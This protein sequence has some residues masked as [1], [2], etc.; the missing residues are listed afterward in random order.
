MMDELIK[1]FLMIIAGCGAIFVCVLTF[2]LL[3]AF[4]PFLFDAVRKLFRYASGK[5]KDNE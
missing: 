2:W 5:Y 1:F 4:I 3:H